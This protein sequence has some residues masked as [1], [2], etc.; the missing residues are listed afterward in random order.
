MSPDPGGTQTRMEAVLCLSH[1]GSEHR[2]LASA[3]SKLR[4]STGSCGPS[5]VAV[6]GEAGVSG[7]NFNLVS[8]AD[9]FPSSAAGGAEPVVKGRLLF[10]LRVLI[11]Q[12]LR[13][14]SQNHS[15]HT[16]SACRL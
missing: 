7:S 12:Y 11:S 1:L 10:L 5:Q 14:S 9:D 3:L 6:G 13:T 16:A 4:A 8:H 15:P 2:C